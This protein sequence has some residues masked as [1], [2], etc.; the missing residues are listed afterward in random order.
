MQG[1]KSSFCCPRMNF[2][3]DCWSKAPGATF[4]N[5]LFK[6]WEEVQL[7]M[8][9][10]EGCHPFIETPGVFVPNVTMLVV[11]VVNV[12]LQAK[13]H[14]LHNVTAWLHC[15][16]ILY[17][18]LQ[19]AKQRNPN[20][21]GEPSS[22]VDTH[23][24][25]WFLFYY[26]L[27][28]TWRG[29]SSE[30]C[31]FWGTPWNLHK[32]FQTPPKKLVKVLEE[33]GKSPLL[34]LMSAVVPCRHFVLNMILYVGICALLKIVCAHYNISFHPS[35]LCVSVWQIAIYID[36]VL[37]GWVGIVGMRLESRRQS[38]SQFCA[39]FT[40]FLANDLDDPDRPVSCKE[41]SLTAVFFTKKRRRD[42]RNLSLT[43]RA[44]IF[45]RW[46]NLT[47]H[48]LTH[49]SSVRVNMR[50]RRGG[51]EALPGGRLGKPLSLLICFV[52]SH[53]GRLSHAIL[54][55]ICVRKCN[56]TIIPM[57]Y[58]AKFIEANSAQ[59]FKCWNVLLELLKGGICTTLLLNNNQIYVTC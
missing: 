41:D 9:S 46:R 59:R 16:T 37:S 42:R 29:I 20:V 56:K 55:K 2:F 31:W 35:N 48:M 53:A 7:L 50:F 11:P 52:H 17:L 32:L 23:L 34:T 54:I 19:A 12:N 22:Q 8:E 40:I 30:Y 49:H 28:F 58:Q 45:G 21:S 3:S 27:D 4:F 47:K 38:R 44:C 51:T 36:V 26:E 15:V 33:A 14:K 5:F 6:H 24:G 57:L 25:N 43:R 13:A 1:S 39:N 10:D 18:N